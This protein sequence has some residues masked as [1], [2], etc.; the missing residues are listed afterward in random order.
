MA[1]SCVRKTKPLLVCALVVVFL[2]SFG[3]KVLAAQEGDFIFSVTG[4][5]AWITRYT[6]PGGD[7]T[8]PSSLGGAPVTS[9]GDR[10][11][12]NCT[13]LTSIIIPEGVSSLG[14]GAFSGCKSLKSISLPQSL[15]VIGDLAF[16]NCTSLKSITIPKNAALLGEDTF[17]G[18]TNLTTVNRGSTPAVKYKEA[19]RRVAS[20]SDGYSRITATVTLPTREKA[21]DLNVTS[22]NGAASYNYLGCRGKGSDGSNY[23]FEFG[24]GF[25]PVENRMMQ[26]GIYYS[27][28]AKSGEES[29]REWN[30]LRP[31]KGTK[32]FYAFD[33]GTTHHIR[34]AA[35]DGEIRATIHDEDNNLEYAGSWSFS[36]F[37][38]KGSEQEVRRVTSL[39]VPEDKSATAKNYS[40]TATNIGTSSNLK[41]A[42][43]LNCK[44][45]TS[46]S[47]GDEWIEVVTDAEFYLEKVSFDVD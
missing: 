41:T 35:C 37:T 38:E 42:N 14:E 1:L 16:E 20:A 40:W 5:Q 15:S 4:G 7:L 29:I 6:G 32:S 2:F 27:L 34:L 36:G 22:S 43:P 47:G 31:E 21:E 9:I 12:Q 24:F 19:Y 23:D 26:F 30:W 44:A 8:L 17:K 18:C 46:T 25:K 45:T 11:F 10:A 13:G 39:L 28:K 33:Y 3:N